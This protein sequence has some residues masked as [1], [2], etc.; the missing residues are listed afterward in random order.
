MTVANSFTTSRLE[1]HAAITHQR[2]TNQSAPC[3]KRE[4]E[5]E[6]Q[7]CRK[8][9]CFKGRKGKEDTK[10]IRGK[11]MMKEGKKK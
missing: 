11:E 7:L 8:L 6:K 10:G 2:L 9:V 3:Q 5:V 1:F 4:T